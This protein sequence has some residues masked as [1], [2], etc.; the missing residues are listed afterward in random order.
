MLERLK[1]WGDKFITEQHFT[2]RDF[3]EAVSQ[4]SLEMDGDG[5]M[6]VLSQWS[7]TA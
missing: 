4:F 5:Q 2:K 7:L 6:S 1:S 3:S